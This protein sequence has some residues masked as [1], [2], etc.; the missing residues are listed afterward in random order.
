MHIILKSYKRTDFQNLICTTTLP[1]MLPMQLS[2][3]TK[4]RLEVWQV[5]QLGIV[6][7]STAQL[8]TDPSH[9]PILICLSFYLVHRYCTPQLGREV[10]RALPL[11][12]K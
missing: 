1:P 9:L 3:H 11:Y 7:L 6:L 5:G 8:R 10:R 2:I 12:P 4:T